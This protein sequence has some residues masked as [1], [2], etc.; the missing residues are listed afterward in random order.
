MQMMLLILLS[1]LMFCGC[2]K[3]AAGGTRPAIDLVVVGKDTTW[4]DG[5]ILKVAKRDRNSIAGIHLVIQTV[6]GQA[7]ITAPTGE[8]VPGS[9]FSA[10]DQE[11]VRVT[12]HNAYEQSTTTNENVGDFKIMLQEK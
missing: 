8:L 10:G 6:G 2:S 7:T 4:K 1:S 3:K 5:S 9:Y 12:L 11:C